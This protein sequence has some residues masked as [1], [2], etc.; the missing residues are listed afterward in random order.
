LA[1]GEAWLDSGHV[2]TR[3]DGSPLHPEYLSTVFETHTRRAGLRRIR[4]HDTRHT[5]ATLALQAGEKTEVVSRWLRHASV[6]ITQDIYQH[7][8]PSM[9]AETG[10]RLDEI[11]FSW[12]RTLVPAVPLGPE[13]RRRERRLSLGSA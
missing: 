3:E 12:R 4:L 7:V 13:R 10:E 2:F 9:I 8:L 1:W 6:S 5:R 11:V